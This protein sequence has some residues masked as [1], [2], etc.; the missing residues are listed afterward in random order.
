MT[1][2]TRRSPDYRVHLH[3]TKKPWGNNMVPTWPFRHNQINTVVKSVYSDQFDFSIKFRF[4]YDKKAHIF[5]ITSVKCNIV[6]RRYEQNLKVVNYCNIL[7]TKRLVFQWN[8]NWID[9]LNY[10]FHET[11]KHKLKNHVTNRF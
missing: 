5:L 11:R 2:I 9:C 8:C 10:A 4:W 6:F 1:R 3:Q 7:Y